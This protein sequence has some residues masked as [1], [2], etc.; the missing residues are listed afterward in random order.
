MATRQFISTDLLS[1]LSTPL[2]SR[3]TIPL[4]KLLIS[5]DAERKPLLEFGVTMLIYT[6]IKYMSPD[7]VCIAMGDNQPYLIFPS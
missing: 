3:W 4:R 5:N 1:L 2:T 7:Y 6:A